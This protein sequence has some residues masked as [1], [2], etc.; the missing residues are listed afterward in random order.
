M[1]QRTYP[2]WKRKK[3]GKKEEGWGRR[4]SKAYRIFF[5]SGFFV[6]STPLKF[7]YFQDKPIRLTF[8]IPFSSWFTNSRLNKTIRL[9]ADREI[10]TG[11]KFK[12]G[13]KRTVGK[14]KKLGLRKE[15]SLIEK[16]DK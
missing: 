2:C 6:F 5:C 15:R 4:H 13:E 14:D 1:D 11:K 16:K 9:V 8:L 10:E 12:E 7:S 3:N